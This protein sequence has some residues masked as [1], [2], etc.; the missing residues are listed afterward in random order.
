MAMTY[1][2]V[3]CLA[4]ASCLL[5]ACGGTDPDAD[6]LGADAGDGAQTG[7]PIPTQPKPQVVGPV[8]VS[9]N[10]IA[11][12][13]A[14]N[15][16]RVANA[17][18]P[19]FTMSDTVYAGLAPG[20]SGSDAKVYWSYQDGYSHKEETKPL[21]PDGVVFAFDSATGMKPGRYNVQID[22]DGRPVG[23]TGFEVR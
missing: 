21:G 19:S 18:R 13:T 8:E 11:V 6:V 16:N 23:I 12:G 22:V 17:A 2:R 4:L 20:I 15:G 10:A 1:P 14:M 7:N 5:A 3:I 9:S